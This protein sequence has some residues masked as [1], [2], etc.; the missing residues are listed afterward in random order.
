M[1][2]FS[3]V[4]PILVD[5]AKVTF[6]LDSKFVAVIFS[7]TIHTE[8]NFFVGTRFR[9]SDPPRKPRK[10]VP[11]K[12]KPSAE[13]IQYTYKNLWLDLSYGKHIRWFIR[14]SHTVPEISCHSS[15]SSTETPWTPHTSASYYLYRPLSKRIWRYPM[16]YRDGHSRSSYHCYPDVHPPRILEV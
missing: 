12:I 1:A 5:W 13:F 11:P 4:P 3:W 16:V 14:T 15:Q 8:N 2:L 7:F 10:L 6:S 9:G